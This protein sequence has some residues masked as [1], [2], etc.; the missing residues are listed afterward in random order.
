[1]NTA[2]SVDPGRDLGFDLLWRDAERILYR[3]WREDAGGRMVPVLAVLPSVSHPKPDSLGRLAHE[4]GLK[5]SLDSAWAARPLEFVRE[6][7]L[8]FLEDSGGE[9]LARLVGAPMELGRFLRLAIALSGAVARLHANGLIHK[10]IKP[11]NVLVSLTT[12][13]VWL[14]GFGIASRAPRER[15]SPAP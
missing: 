12:N 8:L 6:R 1:M 2:S 10:D 13:T 4:Y 7:G 9:P 5:E 11:S 3:G 15:E 14:T